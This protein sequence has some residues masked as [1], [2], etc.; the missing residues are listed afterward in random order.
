MRIAPGILLVMFLS[1]SFLVGG[2]IAEA[3][4]LLVPD[5][6]PTIQAGIDAASS[7]DTVLVADGT[8]TDEGNK[9]LDFKGKAIIVKSENGP[10]NCTIDCGNDGRGFYFASSLEMM[11][12]IVASTAFVRPASLAAVFISV[13]VV[14]Q[15]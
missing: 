2:T 9:N 1:V 4:T 15:H 6:Q 14:P 8:Y 7:G 12:V 10:T 5:Q 3:A 13:K 11:P